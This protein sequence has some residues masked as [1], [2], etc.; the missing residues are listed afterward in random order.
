MQHV[1]RSLA[2]PLD[3]GRRVVRSRVVGSLILALV[4]TTAVGACGSSRHASGFCGRIEQSNPAF[5][6]D[7]TSRA[8]LAAFDKIADTAP[9][10]IAKD[11]HTVSAFRRTLVNDPQSLAAHPSI[12]TAYVASTKRID[13]YLHDTCGI[14]V[15]PEGKLF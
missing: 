13:T 6:S 10:P 15:P 8:A 12:L 3:Y 14:S 5:D 4:A 9:P 7:D 2:S 11:L 1:A